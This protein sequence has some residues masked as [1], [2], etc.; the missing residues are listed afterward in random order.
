[1]SLKNSTT[2]IF[3]EVLILVSL[4]FVI[5]NYIRNVSETIKSDGMGYYDYLP[6]L[7]IHHDLVRKD[8]PKDT[9][10]HL[11]KRIEDT[12]VYNH[13]NGYMVNKYPCGTAILEL[14]FFLKTWLSIPR[15]NLPSDGYQPEY[16]R[17][18]FHAALA[19]LFLSIVFLR[20]LLLTYSINRWII[21]ILQLFMV[22]GTSVTNYVNF[23]AS[24]SHVFSLFAI[25]SFLYFSRVFFQ[26]HSIKHFLFASVMLGVIFTLRNPNLLILF[27]IPFIS[28]SWQQLSSGVVFLFKN[29]AIALL[30]VSIFI[31]IASIQLVLWY[32]QTGDFFVY[33]YQGEGFNF[34]KP[35]FF[36]VLFS[37]K[38][39]LFIYQPILFVMLLGVVWLFV[40]RQFYLFLSWML[41]FIVITYFISSW[42]VWS[43]GASFGMRVYIDFYAV[44]FIPFA[45]MLN[46]SRLWM[47]LVVLTFGFICIPLN[48]IQSIQYKEYILHWGSMD[49]EKYWKV[50]LKTDNKFKGLIWKEKYEGFSNVAPPKVIIGDVLLSSDGYARISISADHFDSLSFLDNIRVELWDD[51]DPTENS[52]IQIHVLQSNGEVVG[53]R[54][55]HHIHFHEKDLNTH[56][57]GMY[58][59]RFDS[60]PVDGKTQVIIEFLSQQSVKMFGDVS[61]SFFGKD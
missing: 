9:A 49:K 40:R 5:N 43:Y 19:Y 15:N 59:Y 35:H 48:I 55:T 4:I 22:L 58:D 11:Y 25:T 27:F 30:G 7:F 24:F 51:F 6:S 47:K 38:K 50:F 37:Y 44:F 20:K 53:W 21:I 61:I 56:H 60:V 33:S 41:F 17:S 2:F 26:Q 52:F 23:D 54:N 34:L 10:P 57:L 36:D 16:H 18:I 39:G 42:W 12:Q 13:Y 32:V 28:G 14:P 8:Q 45:L 31:C 3:T 46:E 29:K 1:M